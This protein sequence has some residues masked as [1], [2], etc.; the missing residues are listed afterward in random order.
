MNIIAFSGKKQSGKTTAVEYLLDILCEPA[1]QI[2]EEISFADCLKE[3]FMTYFLYPTGHEC[4]IEQLNDEEFKNRTHPCGKTFREILQLLGT[5]IARN[6][7]PDIWVENLKYEIQGRGPEIAIVPD[8]RFPNEV[9]CVQDL[10]G[11]VIRLLR[12]PHNDQHE[13]E[14]AL[15]DMQFMTTEAYS[16]TKD[17]YW[18]SDP[19]IYL[20]D[21]IID[22]REMSVEECNEAVWKLVQ[23][24]SWV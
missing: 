16:D 6:I 14:T 24:R 23:E 13:S 8:V 3:M 11:H 12:N 15:D 22:N 7:W 17:T 10:G 20:F 9:K 2:V 4:V 19:D 5:D 21:A 1:D 18:L